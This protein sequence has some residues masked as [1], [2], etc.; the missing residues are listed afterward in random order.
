M[1]TAGI[2]TLERFRRRGR[3]EILDATLEP[4]DLVGVQPLHLSDDIFAVLQRCAGE[5]LEGF[6]GRVRSAL[7]EEIMRRLPSR[8]SILRA[9]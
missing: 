5:I 4:G 9:L 6:Q 3:P 1:Q 8:C 2:D 7:P